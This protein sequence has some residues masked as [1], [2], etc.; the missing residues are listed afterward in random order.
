MEIVWIIL[1]AVVSAVVTWLVV[2]R[3]THSAAAKER[4]ELMMLRQRTA[5]QSAAAGAALQAVESLRNDVSTLQQERAAITAQLEAAKSQAVERRQLFDAARAEAQLAARSAEELRSHLAALQQERATLLA[6]LEAEKKNLAD[7]RQQFDQSR[8]RLRESFAELSQEALK[9]NARVFAESAEQRFK[10]LQAE[11]TGSLDQRK[12]EIAQLLQPMSQVL[13][14]YKEK[15]DSIEKVRNEAYNGISQQL[16]AVAATQQHLSKETTQLV[17][18]LRKPQG[19]GR[20]GELTLKRLFEMASLA[21]R[22]TFHEQVTT[23]DGKLRP[24]CIVQLPEERQVI[25]DSKCVIDAFLDA[26]SADDIARPGHLIRHARQVRE[27]VND[28]SSKAYW[29]HFGKGTDF[30]VLFLPG[31]AFLYAAVEQDP[32]LIEYALKQR[33]IVASPTT[34]LG[35]LRVIEHAWRQKQVEANAEQIRE[36][37]AELYKRVATLAEHFTKIGKNLATATSAYNE[38]LGSLERNVFTS[39]RR[40]SKLGVSASKKLE[41]PVEIDETVRHLNPRS[42]TALPEPPL[43]DAAVDDLPELPSLEAPLESP[44][45]PVAQ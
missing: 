37:G 31:E 42:W 40:M 41:T 27:R 7:Q 5:D 2:E 34:L 15:L 35:L 38:A 45:E 1:T 17:T 11:A 33:V 8:E 36:A 32:E 30:V 24:D 12:A 21:E 25:V 3:R 28:L 22:V 18:A 16:A 19:R 43:D 26:S 9:N 23:D 20:W 13:D 4:A 29:D 6:Q 39:A 14:Q 10:T 44:S